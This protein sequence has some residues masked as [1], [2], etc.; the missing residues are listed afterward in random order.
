MRLPSRPRVPPLIHTKTQPWYL[1]GPASRPLIFNVICQEQRLEGIGAWDSKSK[2]CNSAMAQLSYKQPR[3]CAN[4]STF[5]IRAPFL[6]R[7][8][9]KGS[10]G[11][12]Q[13]GSL[14]S[15]CHVHWRKRSEKQIQRHDVSVHFA[16]SKEGACT[17]LPSY[18]TRRGSLRRQQAPPH[19][20]AT[21]P[22]WRAHHHQ[23]CRA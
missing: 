15:K 13:A 17:S 7:H 3:T 19:R 11:L 22:P 10:R 9:L 2:S 20:R 4:R 12:R 5:H 8:L 1:R 23:A 14:S 6:I 16:R 18:Q 21:A